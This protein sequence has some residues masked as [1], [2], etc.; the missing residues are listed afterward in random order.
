MPFSKIKKDFLDAS[1]VISFKDNLST[2]P[3]TLS[4]SLSYQLAYKYTLF[5][6]ELIKSA[7]TSNINIDASQQQIDAE[8]V[9]GSSIVINIHGSPTA[10]SVFND[11]IRTPLESFLRKSP[12]KE[13]I[14]L[15]DGLDESI[16]QAAEESDNIIS[17]LSNLAALKNVYFVITTRDYDNLLNKFKKNSLIFDISSNKYVNYVNEDVSSFIRLNINKKKLPLEKNQGFTDNMVDRLIKK[18]EGNFLYIKFVMDA[19]V[20]GKINFSQ[21]EVDKMPFGLYGMYGVFFDRMLSQYGQSNWGTFYLPIIRSLLVSFEGLNSNQLSFFTGIEDNLQQVLI[22]LKPFIVLQKLTEG[23]RKSDSVRYKLYHQSLVEFLKTEYLGDSQNSFYIPEQRG[24]KK[25]VEKYYD[26]TAGKFN[27]GLLNEYG[28]R[29][30]SGHLF[31]LFDYDDPE[32]TDWYAKLLELAKDKEFEEKQRQYFP[33]ETNLPLKTIKRAYEA[34][35]EKDDPVSTAEM[36]L[37]YT[38]KLEKIFLESP[39][40]I[41]KNTNLDNSDI[42]EKS[43]RIADLYDKR[44]RIIWYLA[45]AWYLDCKNERT[46]VQKILDRLFGK[47]LVSSGGSIMVKFFVY[48]LYDQYKNKMVEIFNHISN[49]DIYEISSFFF[50]NNNLKTGIEIFNRIGNEKAKVNI[51]NDLNSNKLDTENSLV[52]EFIEKCKTSSIGYRSKASPQ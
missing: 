10:I 37:L 3:K 19:F 44:T 25:I 8:T 11:L 28:L 42:L 35:L 32:G 40:S 48:S 15:I 45:I 34:S 14:I 51:I 5:Y 6:S 21:E 41:L 1:Y 26:K 33:F 29:Y 27:I 24:H 13:L 39:L 22:N 50:K 7:K 17:I 16:T 12:Q 31:A 20:E 4:E 18:A 52:A 9:E 46:N 30:L 47:E 38:D 2:N 36:L 49:D 43:L 23:I